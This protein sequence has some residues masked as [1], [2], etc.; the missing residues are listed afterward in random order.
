MVSDFKDASHLF[1][2]FINW[3]VR[4]ARETPYLISRLKSWR[5]RNIADVA[6]GSG[7]HATALA[8]AGFQVTAV[9]PDKK[10]LEEAQ[11]LAR[12]K[13]LKMRFKQASFEDLPGDL[14]SVSDCVI[15]LGNSLSLIET[16]GPLDQTVLNLSGLLKSEGRLII[17]TINYPMLER[18]PQDPWGP[19]RVTD[20]GS[21]LLKGFIPH[22]G[23]PWDAILIHIFES[24]GK[25]W[26]REVVRFCLHPHEIHDMK[27]AGEKAGLSLLATYGGF[28]KEKPDSPEAGDLLY[29]FQKT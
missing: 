17:H 13:N 21:F 15:C 9:D 5:A 22:S 11:G 14:A 25:G 2:L 29:E 8:E 4:L 3:K 10:L 26:T 24:A 19:V 7:R 16:G 12:A 18:R 23:R 28:N 6:C 20:D 27:A 1:E